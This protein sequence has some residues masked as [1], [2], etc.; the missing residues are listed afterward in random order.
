M[1]GRMSQYE[2][3][4]T[5]IGVMTAWASDNDDEPEFTA[6]YLASLTAGG[7]VKD[8]VLTQAQIISGLVNLAGS[9]L[10]L[11]DAE[12]GVPPQA[13]LRELAQHIADK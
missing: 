12:T 7:T 9:L 6:R 2:N 3:T 11:R 13:T 10:V 1:M 5:A 4:R 8:Q